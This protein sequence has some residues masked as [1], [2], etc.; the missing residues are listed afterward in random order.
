MRNTDSVEANTRKGQ[1]TPTLQAAKACAEW[2]SLCV[3]ELGWKKSQIPDLEKLWWEQHDRFG[4][5]TST[6]N[7]P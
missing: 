4:H 5:L 6:P 2:V 1:I 7:T 3:T